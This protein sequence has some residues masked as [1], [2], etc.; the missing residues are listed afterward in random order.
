MMDPSK[1]QRIK[2]AKAMHSVAKA[3]A[4]GEFAG[5]AA[6]SSAQVLANLFPNY[7]AFLQL[8]GARA[9]KQGP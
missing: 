7:F 4:W 1:V 5:I 2:V 8:H 6:S 9:V 3:S